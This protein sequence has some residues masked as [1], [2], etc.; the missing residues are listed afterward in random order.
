MSHVAGWCWTILILLAMCAVPAR[1]YQRALKIILLL[2]IFPIAF[3]LLV[4]L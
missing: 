3:L 2:A 1:A 4:W